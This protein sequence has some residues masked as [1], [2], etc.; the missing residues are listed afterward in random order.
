[1]F[2]L[3]IKYYIAKRNNCDSEKEED[4]RLL[5]SIHYEGKRFIFYPGIY[6]SSFQWNKSLQ[7][8]ENRAD[9]ERLNVLLDNLIKESEQI[10]RSLKVQNGN[11]ELS[12]FKKAISELKIEQQ[13]S[14]T[15]ALIK[16]IEDRVDS[17]SN[18]TYLKF[19]TLYR[20][21]CD[22]ESSHGLNL[23]IESADKKFLISFYNYLLSKSLQVSTA[24]TYMNNLKGFLTYA[25]KMKWMLNKDYLNYKR[26]V[27]SQTNNKEQVFCYLNYSELT[28]LFKLQLNNRR[29]EQCRDIYCFIAFTG[30]R[31]NEINE[32]SANSLKNNN[33]HIA[34]KRARIIPLNK[35]ALEIVQKYENRFYR[36]NSL[37]PVYSLITVNKYLQLIYKVKD[38]SFCKVEGYQDQ[39]ITVNSAFNTFMANAVHFGISPAIVRKWSANKTLSRYSAIKKSIED[40]EFHELEIINQQ[41]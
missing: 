41:F 26:Q 8:V 33:L 16:F 20:K 19:K 7:R 36:N 35:F 18:N 38:I 40:A 28:E 11:V 17:W 34:G 12:R 4:F 27:L 37:F 14:L 5:M 24:I 15:H 22:Y 13:F 39:K 2:K 21:I 30:I 25:V 3:S 6:L 10:F 32:L 31:F 23:S 29:M 1:M 9:S